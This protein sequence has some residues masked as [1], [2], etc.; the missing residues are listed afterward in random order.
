MVLKEMRLII[1][2]LVLIV[3]LWCVY[4]KNQEPK[5]FFGGNER[6]K[7]TVLLN[8][9]FC[10]PIEY[11]SFK[12]ED[13]VN[14]EINNRKSLALSIPFTI[15]PI[16][17]QEN[18]ATNMIG[19]NVSILLVYDN[20]M[21]QI[22]KQRVFDELR[23]YAIKKNIQLSARLLED[24]LVGEINIF[25]FEKD[26]VY[27]ICKDLPPNRDMFCSAYTPWSKSSN[28]SDME[29]Q[30]SIARQDVLKWQEKEQIVRAFLNRYATN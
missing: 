10:I 29:L 17:P 21:Y 9:K 11:Y 25:A 16:L 2:L 22:K 15:L 1:F 7:A 28:N 23:S 26:Q 19:Q 5:Q 14:W 4:Q 18:N 6:C 12:D 20:E 30:F 8:V 13:T 3:V 24:F 27:F